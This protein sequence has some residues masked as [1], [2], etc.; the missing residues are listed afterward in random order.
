[1]SLDAAV[2]LAGTVLNATLLV[3]LLWRRVFRVLP[4]F[5]AYIAYSLIFVLTNLMPSHD[6][7][8]YVLLRS[9]ATAIDML[10]YLSVLVELDKCVHLHN[11]TSPLPEALVLLLFALVSVPIWLLAPWSPPAG[12]TLAWRLNFRAVQSTAIFEVAGI[13][14]M[15]WLTN[16]QHLHWPERAFRLATGLGA[17][18]MVQ[19]C[20]LIAHENGL[21]GA[22]Y[23]WL[24]LLTPTAAIGVTLYWLQ[25]FWFDPSSGVQS[26]RDNAGDA[27]Q[28]AR[29][30]VEEFST[31]DGS[32][33]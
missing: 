26:G 3:L 31:T 23:H 29:S 21:L 30:M 18:A 25:Y 15:T 17:W 10:F 4:V 1:M 20:V 19:L 28:A 5:V 7:R 13:L 9:A 14:T 27:I 33:G 32:E 24:D 11:E 16:R 22:S 2:M 8:S 12:W 6:A